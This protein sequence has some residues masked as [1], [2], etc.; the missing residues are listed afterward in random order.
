MLQNHRERVFSF[1]TQVRPLLLFCRER[2][3]LTGPTGGPGG[4]GIELILG[5]GQILSNLTGGY[6]DIV[7]WDPR[8]VGYTTPGLI[9]CFHSSDEY[10]TFW[11]G[12]LVFPQID[13]KYGFSDPKDLAYF[14]SQVNVM[15]ERWKA[16]GKVC[17]KH[18][19]GQFLPYVGT[20]ATVRDLV[21][22]AEYFDGKGCDINYYGLSY[23]TTIGNYLINMFPNR[24]GRIILDGMEDPV[25][26]ASK[27]SHLYWGHRVE[28]VDETFQGFAQGCALAGPHG[29]PLATSTSTGSGI[30]EWTK[31]LLS[32]AHDYARSSGDDNFR[33]VHLVSAIHQALYNPS[34]WA[35]FASGQF[36]QFYQE[37]VKASGSNLT[38][39]TRST[40]APP[41]LKRQSGQDWPDYTFHAISCGDSIDESNI[42]SQAVFDELIRVVKDVSPVFGGQFP[43]PGHYCHRWPSRAVERFTGPWNSTLKNPIII[44]GNKAD[45][46]TPFLDA[47]LVAGWLGKSATLVEQDGYGHLSL[48]QKSTCTQNIVSNFFINGVHPQG[49]GTICEIDPDGP[50]LFPSKGVRASDIRSAISSDG[51]ATTPNSQELD[52]LKTQKKSLFIAVIALAAACGIL[53]ISLIFSCF[54]GRRGR[55]YKPVGTRG[56]HGQKVEF[57]GYDAD[58][59]YSDPYDSKH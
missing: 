38:L 10:V 31:S 11:N 6:Y 40:W 29:C 58:R 44:I 5:Y 3:L 1:P 25:T 59:S 16:F 35:S 4:S 53:L 33:S 52:D 7:S 50:Q 22:I 26:H 51:N 13:I 9:N 18:E 14:N 47:S 24:V 15:E 34:Q 20:T 43:Q 17:L 49:N 28:S 36:L 46:A 45:P 57:V 23:G 27:P 2:S 56:A 48:A 12:T 19:T 54:A 32:L 37:L 41:E 30:V 55:G 42:T 39:A 8:G 21:A